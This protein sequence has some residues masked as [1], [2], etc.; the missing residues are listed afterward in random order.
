MF[1]THTNTSNGKETLT[2][3]YYKGAG[4]RKYFGKTGRGRMNLLV[5]CREVWGPFQVD[6]SE[7]SRVKDSLH[8]QP[9][10]GA[11]PHTHTHTACSLAGSLPKYSA[12]EEAKYRGPAWATLIPHTPTPT[13]T[14]AHMQIP[15]HIPE[16][17][18]T[19]YPENENGDS[20]GEQ[21]TLFSFY[22]RM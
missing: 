11:P 21:G 5:T 2:W 4:H 13:H 16:L 19:H 18:C 22:R 20:P 7:G 17:F 10:G 8:R 9:A 12:Q 3:C 15:Q 6:L 1:L 14:H